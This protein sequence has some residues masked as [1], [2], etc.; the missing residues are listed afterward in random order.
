MQHKCDQHVPPV[1]H[2]HEFEEEEEMQNV[3]EIM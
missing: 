1:K 3:I 2:L